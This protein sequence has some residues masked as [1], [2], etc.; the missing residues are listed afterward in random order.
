MRHRTRLAAAAAMISLA[1]AAP[2]SLAAAATTPG[3]PAATPPPSVARQPAVQGSVAASTLTITV[4]HSTYRFPAAALLAHT[5]TTSHAAGRSA[6]Q[7]RSSGAKQTL[8]VTATNLAGK[9]DNGDAVL[10]ANAD[11]SDIFGQNPNVSIQHFSGGVATYHVPAGPYWAIGIFGG[12]LDSHNE[13]YYRRLVVLPQFSVTGKTTEHIA[14]QAATSKITMVTPRPATAVS[15]NF[16]IDHPGNTGPPVQLNFSNTTLQPAASNPPVPPLWVSPTTQR[17]TAGSLHTYASQQLASPAGP[18]QPYRYAV[19]YL[20]RSGTIPEQRYVVAPKDLATVNE[21]YYQAG[22]Q[23]VQIALYGSLLTSLNGYMNPAPFLA[24]AP[25]TL[26]AYL[27][28]NVPNMT[29]QGYDLTLNK[30]GNY[31]AGKFGEFVPIPPG[32]H[33]TQSWNAYPLHP[34]VNDNPEPNGWA[35]G[36]QP[37]ALRLGDKLLLNVIPSGDNQP[38]HS[39]TGF[40][41]LGSDKISGSYV[42]DQNGKQ[43]AGGPTPPAQG[44]STEFST[45]ATLSSK[46]SVVSFGLNV[47]SSGPAF[48][49]ST[50]THTVWTWHTDQ[51]PGVKLPGDWYCQGTPT[52]FIDKCVVQ[53]M[54]TLRYAVAGL[55]LNGQVPAGPEVVNL[56]VGHLQLV[57]PIAITKVAMSVSFDGG[58][59]WQPAQVT[60]HGGAY[61]AAFTAPAGAYVMTRTHA[62]DAAGGSVSETITRAFGVAS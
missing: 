56:T 23:P 44:G 27:G 15:T 24:S 37:S 5:P 25:H 9:P 62:E 52:G 54:M 50:A 42:I 55:A 17:P 2:A 49:L 30:E 53:P 11:N 45:K 38:G 14:E 48:P 20:N 7:P 19:E 28:G 51:R 47:A 18:G 4:G 43:I 33:T 3:L 39:G 12:T 46:P 57:K 35:N 36:L 1:A 58:K 21:R 41:H 29:W 59:T 32:T 16:T 60:G 34:G 22:R 31:A 8:T 10:V 61:R 6:T 26:T 13:A 40:E